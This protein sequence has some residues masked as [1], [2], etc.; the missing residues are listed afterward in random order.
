LDSNVY[1][2]T[3]NGRQAVDLDKF[4]AFFFDLDGTIYTGSKLLPGVESAISSLIQKKKKVMYLTNTSI[5]TRQDCCTRLRR[6]GLDPAIDDIVTGGFIASM[7]LQEHDPNANVYVIGEEALVKELDA[8]GIRR[9][10][11]PLRATHLLVG[12]DRQFTYEKLRLAMLAVRNGAQLIATNPDPYCPV[13]DGNIPDTWPIAKAIEA[14]STLQIH[15][16]TGKPSAYYANKVL[17]LSGMQAD[18]CLMVGDRLET[19]ILLG[20]N[21]GLKTA[22]VLTG[23]TSINDLAL[24]DIV[25]DYVL[26]TLDEL[27]RESAQDIKDGAGR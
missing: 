8:F 10:D 7:Y 21:S 3:G 11:D 20:K 6:L 13:P 26:T 1:A 5:Y 14:A 27:C 18:R 24:Q 4:E 16:V 12:M 17:Q 9:S 19:D 25:P 23:V 15:T 2:V 22:L